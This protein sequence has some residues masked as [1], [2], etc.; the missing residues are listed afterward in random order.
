MPQNHPLNITTSKP[1]NPLLTTPQV[2]LS[3]SSITLLSLS[4]SDPSPALCTPSKILLPE[5][6]Q[7]PSLT[8]PAP[9]YAKNHIKTRHHP[10]TR[11][12]GGGWCRVE[13]GV[14]PRISGGGGGMFK[15]HLKIHPK[16]HLRAQRLAVL[17]V[18]AEGLGS[19]ICLWIF[20]YFSSLSFAKISS[21]PVGLE[22]AA[23]AEL[24][25]FARSCCAFSLAPSSSPAQP[26]KGSRLRGEPPP[27]RFGRERGREGREP[28]PGPP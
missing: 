8:T 15:I 17:G 4:P 16:I 11:D 14:L 22:P 26:P 21:S 6:T 3:S 23:R 7:T 18:A 10:L 24:S 27:H 2:P 13:I 20:R 12:A 19:L 1:L 25:R 5:P 9:K 28:C